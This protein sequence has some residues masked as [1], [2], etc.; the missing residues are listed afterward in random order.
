LR[1]EEWE[2][3]GHTSQEIFEC[4]ERRRKTGRGGTYFMRGSENSSEDICN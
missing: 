4:G 2:V 3:K 1:R